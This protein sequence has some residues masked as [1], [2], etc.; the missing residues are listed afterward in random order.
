MTVRVRFVGLWGWV[1]RG[2]RHRRWLGWRLGP[3]VEGGEG[4]TGAMS[5]SRVENKERRHRRPRI[6]EEAKGSYENRD[7]SWC[8]MGAVARGTSV[9]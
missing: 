2:A 7:K 6:T 5:N 8:W 1:G 4:T 9:Y 3:A